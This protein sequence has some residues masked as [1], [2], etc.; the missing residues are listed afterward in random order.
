LC[1]NIIICTGVE[2]STVGVKLNQVIMIKLY[3]KTL[4][5]LILAA[6]IAFN[7]ASLLQWN[8]LYL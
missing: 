4:L 3:D 6:F 5:G 1:K 7:T 8:K 2:F